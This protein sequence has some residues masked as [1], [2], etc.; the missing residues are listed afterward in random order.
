M[1]PAPSLAANFG[2]S[3]AEATAIVQ[4]ADLVVHVGVN[5]YEA[6]HDWDICAGHILVTEAG[7]RVTGTGGQELQYGLAGAWQRSPALWQT[8]DLC[9][10]GG[11]QRSV[12]V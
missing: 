1:L 7:G 10:P 5:T 12:G 4:A 8:R 6:F 3:V 2:G 11:R 9:E